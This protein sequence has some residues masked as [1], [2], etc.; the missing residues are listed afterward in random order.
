MERDAL[1]VDIG[2]VIID[3]RKRDPEVTEVTE[4]VFASF[5][6]TE[7]VFEALRTLHDYY[8]GKLYLVSKC[9]EW[10]EEQ[11]RLWLEAHEVYAKTGISADHVY[12]VRERKD[13][14]AVCQ[15]LGIAHFVDDRLEVLS[16]MVGS[17]PDLILFQPDQE[18]V[19]QFAHVLPHVVVVQA[20][21]EVVAHLTSKPAT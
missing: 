13:K 16:H 12:F 3:V 4:A 21:S 11:I 15:Q 6:P 10:A 17:T 1:G 19:Q 8:H 2:N 5:P 7:G 14:D 18:E 9:T 20:W